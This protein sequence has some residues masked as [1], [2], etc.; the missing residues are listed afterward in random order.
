MSKAIKKHILP[1]NLA[2]TAAMMGVEPYYGQKEPEEH[3]P[4][5]S[6]GMPVPRPKSE[7]EK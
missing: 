4:F 1:L 3:K 5:V 6:R 7:Y 2:V